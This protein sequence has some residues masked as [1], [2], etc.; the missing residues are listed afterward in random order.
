VA[1]EVEA[2]YARLMQQDKAGDEFVE[3]LSAILS[4][5]FAAEA[6]QRKSGSRRKR[7]AGPLEAGTT[8]AGNGAAHGNCHEAAGAEHEPAAVTSDVRSAAEKI[9]NSEI[10]AETAEKDGNQERPGERRT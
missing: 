2:K 1:D 4:R 7:D 3:A 6:R 9:S 10:L 5:E 8:A